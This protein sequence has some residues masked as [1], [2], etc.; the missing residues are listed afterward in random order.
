M[1]LICVPL[2]C[3]ESCDWPE[4]NNWTPPFCNSLGIPRVNTFLVFRQLLFYYSYLLEEKTSSHTTLCGMQH[5]ENLLSKWEQ[6]IWHHQATAYIHKVHLLNELACTSLNEI[7]RLLTLSISV[8]SW[9]HHYHYKLLPFLNSTP[10]SLQNS[11]CFLTFGSV[12]F[13]KGLPH[14]HF[15]LWL[16]PTV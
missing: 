3:R 15:P 11:S 8:I 13:L 9:A 16:N 12:D 10:Y 5:Q 7:S 14:T 6:N 2:E 4:I 1:S